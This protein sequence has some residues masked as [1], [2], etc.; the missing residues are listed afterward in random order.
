MENFANLVRK[1]RL[2]FD[3][4]ITVLD[5]AKHS[6]IS[7]AARPLLGTLEEVCRINKDT[8]FS[9]KPALLARVVFADPKQESYLLLF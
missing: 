5:P 9:A 2:D 6:K 7:E 1:A 8:G 3:A 4:E